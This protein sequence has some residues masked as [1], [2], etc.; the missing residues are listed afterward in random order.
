MERAARASMN[1]EGGNKLDVNDNLKNLGDTIVCY[2]AKN[3]R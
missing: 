1:G 3:T 2:Q